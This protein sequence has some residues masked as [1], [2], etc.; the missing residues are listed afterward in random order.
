MIEKHIILGVKLILCMYL[1]NSDIRTLLIPVFHECGFGY[2]VSTELLILLINY[3][4]D[5]M[6]IITYTLS[7]YSSLYL[8]YTIL[9][10]MLLGRRIFSWLGSLSPFSLAQSRNHWTASS[11][12]MWKCPDTILSTRRCPRRNSFL[13]SQ[14]RLFD[15]PVAAKKALVHTCFPPMVWVKLLLA[16]Q[17]QALKVVSSQLFWSLQLIAHT[18]ILTLCN[19]SLGTDFKH[20]LPQHPATEKPHK[21]TQ[22]TKG[23]KY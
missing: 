16:G 14:Y 15:M 10:V 19:A 7:E 6:P 2:P 4:N 23:N 9:R 13:I 5:I 22:S 11:V 12:P 3:D 1:W 17:Q 8:S 21:L 20:A 18:F